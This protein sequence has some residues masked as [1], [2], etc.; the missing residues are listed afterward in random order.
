M[1]E[2]LK[3]IQKKIGKTGKASYYFRKRGEKKIRLEGEFGSA[4]FLENY[5]RALEG[6]LVT[7]KRRPTV[8]GKRRLFMRRRDISPD[9]TAGRHVLQGLPKIILRVD[10][11]GLINRLLATRHQPMIVDKRGARLRHRP[12]DNSQFASRTHEALLMPQAR[13]ARAR[14]GLS[15]VRDGGQVVLTITDDGPGVPAGE[16]R[17]LAARGMRDDERGGS[18]GLGLAIVSDILSAYGTRPRFANLEQGG[19]EVTVRLPAAPG[20]AVSRPSR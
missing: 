15:V 4:E 3:Y 10:G 8:R 9:K 7:T 20:E 6:K 2:G 11:V 14:V 1:A 13:H 16:Q 18:A 19:F 17:R 5:A 12:A